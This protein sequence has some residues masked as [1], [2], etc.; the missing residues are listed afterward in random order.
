[1]LLTLL[2]LVALFYVA[3]YLVQR[4][5]RAPALPN[6]VGGVLVV[7][8]FAGFGMHQVLFGAPPAAISPPVAATTNAPATAAPV[9]PTA[10]TTPPHHALSAAAFARLV[11]RS[12][13]TATGVI[14]SLTVAG[15]EPSGDRFRAG[16]TIVVRGWAGDPG[17]KTPD[18]G[19]ILVVD[20]TRRV[21]A[22]RGYGG[23]RPDVAQGLHA[24]VMLRSNLEAPLETAGM[25]KGSH[26]LELAPI[27]ADGRHYEV[28]ES[29]R[30]PFT[31][32]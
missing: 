28:I 10:S 32:N 24:P 12:T 26:W 19:L 21:D 22:T 27:S 30:K 25:P 8:F 5:R 15:V 6:W 1:M 13:R 2:A 7:V 17:S 23:E 18:S 31:L 11:P 4:Y 14:D 16:S 3:K 20:G 9:L 29:T